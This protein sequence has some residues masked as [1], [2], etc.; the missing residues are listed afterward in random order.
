[1][2]PFPLT[3]KIWK[4]KL[5]GF[6]SLFPMSLLNENLRPQWGLL[7]SDNPRFAKTEM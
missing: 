5:G 6:H 4:N 3:E 7:I 1:M 2:G